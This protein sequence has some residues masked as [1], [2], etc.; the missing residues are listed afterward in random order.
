MTSKVTGGDGYLDKSNGE[1]HLILEKNGL[2]KYDG[3]EQW[4]RAFEAACEAYFYGV[5]LDERPY[6]ATRI[7]GQLFGKAENETKESDIITYPKLEE[8]AT[9]ESGKNA[10][11]AV[12]LLMLVIKQSCQSALVISERDSFDKYFRKTKNRK[13]GEE[14]MAFRT[15]R[16]AEYKTM[17]DLNPGTQLSQNLLNYFLLDGMRITEDEHLAT[18]RNSDNSYKDQNKIMEHLKVQ[19]HEIGSKEIDGRRSN[20]KK[21]FAPPSGKSGKTAFG[22]GKGSGGGYSKGKY[23]PKKNMWNFMQDVPSDGEEDAHFRREDEGEWGTSSYPVEDEEDSMPDSEMPENYWADSGDDADASSSAPSSST[24]NA[25][26]YDR[27]E[28]LKEFQNFLQSVDLAS[29]SDNRLIVRPRP[30]RRST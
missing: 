3:E 23:T 18:L 17:T 15:R 12:K 7:K 16:N 13:W 10:W 11:D 2:V 4:Q 25:V 29:L 20:P 1:G 27:A 5:K 21:K 28:G 22:K 8:L 19:F 9:A 26:G 14:V 30:Y 24:G 6:V